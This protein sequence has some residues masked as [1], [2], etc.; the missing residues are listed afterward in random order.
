MMFTFVRWALFPT[1]FFGGL[2]LAHHL[3]LTGASTFE[4]AYTPI[5]LSIVVLMVGERYMP[6]RQEWNRPRGD[7]GTDILHMGLTQVGVGR[8][9]K[10]A[11]AALLAGVLAQASAAVPW[12]GWFDGVPLLIQVFVAMALT[13]L[14][15]YWLHRWSHENRLLWRFHAVHHSPERLYWLN[16]GRFHPFEKAAH[17]A[18]GASVLVALGVSAPVVILHAVYSNIHGMFQ[19]CNIDLRLGRL[20]R[21][22]PMAELHRWHHARDVRDAN[23]NYGNNVAWWDM[24]FG[25]CQEHPAAPPADGVGI[26]NPHIPGGYFGQL[27]APFMWRDKP[28]FQ[29]PRRASGPTRLARP[30]SH[31]PPAPAR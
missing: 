23:A 12:A 5:G 13:D 19:H 21:V 15:R 14:P 9:V 25:T 26:E 28:P 20:N 30:A 16:A 17:T 11:L 2:A 29:Q 3:H 10:G 1:T 6:L 7:V 27:L 24:L 31:V 8:L 22:F 18:L 4:A